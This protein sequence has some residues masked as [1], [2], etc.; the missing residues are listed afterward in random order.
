MRLLVTGA[1]GLVGSAVA[2][3]AAESGHHV[4]G[5][6]GRYAGAIPGAAERQ[7]LDLARLDQIVPRIA[8]LRPETIVHAAA[9]S[10][11]AACDADPEGSERLNVDVPATL[12]RAAAAHGW[13]LLH[14][15]TEQV[16]G[17]DRAP[18]HPSDPVAPRNRYGRQKAESERRVAAL[19]P[20][21][22]V[23]VRA[24]LLMGNSLTGRRSLHERLL[25]EWQAGR[26]PRLFTD[27]VRQVAHAD[28]LAKLL[29][30]LAA[31]PDVQGVLHWAG[32]DA[33]SR[34]DLGVRIRA[35]FHLSPERA[36][37]AAVTR[38]EQPAAADRPADLRLVLSSPVPALRTSPES[39][40]GQ[41]EQLRIPAA[42]RGWLVQ[43]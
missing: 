22:S 31:R 36:P 9:V 42:L 43:F 41:L 28:N 3:I 10:E 19:A 24:P 2:R 13:R 18:Y 32:R 21:R 4:I 38:A 40:A 27:E 39:F 7:A 30:E 15:S 35:H 12:A 37:I 20:G 6:V 23:I 8:A 1:S 11:P 17:G 29:V 26:T 34:H 25:A 16:F 5:L 33:L 14:L